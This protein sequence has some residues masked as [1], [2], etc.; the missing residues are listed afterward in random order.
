MKP[1]N[2]RM[3]ELVSILDKA[4]K[5]YYQEDK[6]LMSNL[7]YDKLYDELLELEKETGII[8]SNSPT[9]KVGYEVLSEL[10]KEEHS[11]PMLSLDKTKEVEG[12]V[13]FLKDKEGILSFKLDG[14]TV[15]LTYEDGKLTKAV[16]R[17]NG[18]IGEIIT[19]NAKMF[20]NLPL[21]INYKEKLIIRGEAIIKYSDF[22]KINEEIKDV[23]AKYKNPRNLCSGS[24][25]QLNNE[26]TS[27]RNVCFYAFSLVES[28][29]S[30]KEIKKDLDHLKELG[31]EVVENYLV[32]SENI[33]NY[34]DKF[35]DKI[36]DYDLP[37]DGLVLVFN[38]K[39]YGESLGRTAKFP[40][41]GIAFKW[42]DE[43]ATT[44]LLEIEWSPSRTGL[45]NPIAI[46][47]PVDLE[48]TTVSRASLHNVSIMENLELGLGDEITVYKANMIIPQIADN[49]TRSANIVIPTKCPVCNTATDLKEDNGI[50][51]LYCINEEC[52]AK[53]IKLFTHFVSRNAM[54]I[55]GLS[56]ETLD[57]FI[58]LGYISTI[59]D[60]YKLEQH[61]NEIKN[62]RGFKEKSVQNILK[63]IDDSKDTEL[64][65]L[66]YGIGISNIGLTNAKMI[67]KHFDND[68]EK[69]VDAKKEELL[70]IDGIGDI[71][72]DSLIDYFAN[73]SKKEEFYKILELLNIKKEVAESGNNL[74]DLV[75]VITGS[76]DIFENRDKLKQYIESESGKVT[77][78][79]TKN[80]NY[81]IN[82][83]VASN[84]SKNKKA[85]ELGVNIITE[86]EF[87]DI[88]NVSLDTS[89]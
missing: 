85:K 67:C 83:D 84:S 65:R 46:F 57:K 13:S 36:K 73:E 14:L 64:Y 41:N 6:E 4:A 76:L 21:S 38:D 39:E 58:E 69:I 3:K 77:G 1:N 11:Y 17:G 61:K 31:F 56:E 12:L 60:I 51:T 80:T 16:T 7:E 29:F 34:V 78:S 66:I 68:V 23:E 48:G 5:A 52:P 79:V 88:F 63:A 32:N 47:E 59:S 25:R 15:V 10:E 62:Q 33:S 55:D 53:K 30:S 18:E 9:I 49:L 74:K 37:S 19:N 89:Q 43:I 8:L 72:A 24:V 75:F 2:V 45:I 82:N 70:E 28:D 86:Q 42:T 81:L 40:R 35:S 71:I 87:V 22:Y 26:I 20:K 54:N 27:K 44:K 50:K